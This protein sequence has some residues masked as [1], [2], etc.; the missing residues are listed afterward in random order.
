MDSCFSAN[1]IITDRTESSVEFYY[2]I[3]NTSI[4]DRFLSDFTLFE[5]EDPAELN[6]SSDAV[7]AVFP[8]PDDPEAPVFFTDGK[9]YT[10]I[11]CP[12]GRDE[13]VRFSVTKKP[14]GKFGSVKA[15]ADFGIRFKGLET[16]RTES[17]RIERTGSVEAGIRLYADR[18]AGAFS[19]LRKP[20]VTE[21][22]C[23]SVSPFIALE[24]D[25]VWQRYPGRALKD[26]NGSPVIFEKDG[27]RY[28]IYDLTDPGVPASFEARFEAL[29]GTPGVTS[30]ELHDT[31]AFLNAEN[32]KY[33]ADTVTPR[34]AYRRAL[35]AIRKGAGGLTLTA[36]DGPVTAYIG[37]ADAFSG[38]PAKVFPLHMTNYWWNNTPSLLSVITA[39]I[40]PVCGP[41]ENHEDT[42]EGGTSAASSMDAASAS[43]L[44]EGTDSARAFLE[45]LD[46]SP[47]EYVLPGWMPEEKKKSAKKKAAE[48]DVDNPLPDTVLLFHPEG[49]LSYYIRINRTDEPKP[50]G[51]FLTKDLL[52]NAA[53]TAENE[54]VQALPGR[55]PLLPKGFRVLDALRRTHTDRAALGAFIPLLPIPAGGISIVR[56]EAVSDFDWHL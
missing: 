24:T 33:R 15:V 4:S 47:M 44:P 8:M 27:C 19:V 42:A 51:F 5:T 50:A 49:T 14:R 48:K 53:S 1:R 2:T 9:L 7:K 25:P 20:R 39:D 35:E 34:R 11:S 26:A 40:L 52:P 18:K 36:T 16:R 12:G 54:G 13:A 32:A 29:S 6:F 23:V 17:V 43:S 21:G 10:M 38:L 31:M 28:R 30:L 55:S 3:T 45:A 46:A 56:I 41:S 37:I 22:M